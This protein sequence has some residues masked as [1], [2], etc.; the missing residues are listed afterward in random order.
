[1][2]VR[3]SIRFPWMLLAALPLALQVGSEASQA[4]QSTP[5]PAAGAAAG[6][7]EFFEARVRPILAANCY[8]CHADERMGGLRLDSRDALLK[9][10]RSGPA[11]VPAIRTRACSS[12]RSGRPARS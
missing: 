7:A 2:E 10:G 1:M 6:S 12:R 4:T 9:G 3:H 8:D 5:A 11:L